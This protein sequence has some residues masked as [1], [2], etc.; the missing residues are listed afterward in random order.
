M[1]V[2]TKQKKIKREIDYNG[3]LPYCELPI[4]MTTFNNNIN[5]YYANIV[6]E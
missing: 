3:Q 5:G 1:S 4:N 6:F 2:T